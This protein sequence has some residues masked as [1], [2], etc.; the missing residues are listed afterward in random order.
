MTND[1]ANSLVN[2]TANPTQQAIF[3][4]DINTSVN[5]I[6][7]LNKYDHSCMVN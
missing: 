7:A 3:V 4:E 5:I 2:I 1:I 6:S